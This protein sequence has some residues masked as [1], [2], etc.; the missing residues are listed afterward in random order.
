M[1]PKLLSAPVVDDE[2]PQKWAPGETIAVELAGVTR[3]VQRSA[4]LFVRAQGD[5]ARLH[6]ATGSHLIRV[7][8]STLQKRWAAAGFVR[9]HRST[10]VALAHI[11][12]VRI[13]GGRFYVR[14]GAHRLQVSRRQGRQVREL[15]AASVA[16]SPADRGQGPRTR[17]R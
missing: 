12:E 6:T 4:V 8:L 17:S 15:L 9:I 3:L 10:L 16:H 13:N 2:P 5:Y 14:L 11:D 7:P 1:M